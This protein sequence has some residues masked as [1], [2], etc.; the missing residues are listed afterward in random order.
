MMKFCI[1]LFSIL[2]FV[3]WKRLNWLVHRLLL[4]SVIMLRWIAPSVYI[5]ILTCFLPKRSTW[6]FV[7]KLSYLY[8]CSS[9]IYRHL[10]IP[11][12]IAR[13]KNNHPP[14][15]FK[16]FKVTSLRSRSYFQKVTMQ[17]FAFPLRSTHGN[18]VRLNKTSYKKLPGAVT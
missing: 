1:L 6:L 15:S 14:M 18:T 16:Y 4:G 11:K 9:Q 3:Y 5:A 12:Y 10:G 8:Q 17:D 13:N 7:I 2:Y